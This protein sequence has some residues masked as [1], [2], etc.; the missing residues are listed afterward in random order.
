M[1]NQDPSAKPT[2]INASMNTPNRNNLLLSLL[3]AGLILSSLT[4]SWL[5]RQEEPREET[6]S[7]L[8]GREENNLQET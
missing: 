1:T 7:D 3:I 6:S 2:P 5:G 8:G 4:A